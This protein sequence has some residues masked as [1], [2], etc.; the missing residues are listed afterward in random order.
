[1]N[2]IIR[3]QFVSKIDITVPFTYGY[4]DIDASIINGEDSAGNSTIE[5]MDANE[6]HSISLS[7][8]DRKLI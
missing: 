6:K 1:M 4:E 8:V 5:T 3:D 2:E 7:D